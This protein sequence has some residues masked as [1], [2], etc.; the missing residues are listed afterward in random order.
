[1]LRAVA[2]SHT[3]A[4]D[5]CAPEWRTVASLLPCRIEEEKVAAPA[6][7]ASRTP[8]SRARGQ[9]WSARGHRDL[10][11]ARQGRRR[12]T[13]QRWRHRRRAERGGRGGARSAAVGHGRRRRGVVSVAG[14]SSS[15]LRVEEEICGAE[16]CPRDTRLATARPTRSLAP[17][18]SQKRLRNASPREQTRAYAGGRLR[19]KSKRYGDAVS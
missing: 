9:I 7:A 12:Q 10:H 14:L 17:W 5:G 19:P 8:P 15:L 4:E 3:D 6:V 13:Q 1:E 18:L 11:N 16:L 2:V